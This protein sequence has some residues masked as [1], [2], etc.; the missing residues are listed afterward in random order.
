M[1]IFKNA[2]Y[3][4]QR[5]FM[6]TSTM[7][8]KGIILPKEA[9]QR[10]AASF[11]LE[12][13]HC[14]SSLELAKGSAKTNL[15]SVLECQEIIDKHVI[16]KEP[17]DGIEKLKI[18]TAL[19]LTDGMDVS[20]M[21]RMSSIIIAANL[22]IVFGEQKEICPDPTFDWS[23]GHL[24]DVMLNDSAAIEI[25]RQEDFVWHKLEPPEKEAFVFDRA[26]IDKH[27][28]IFTRY[29]NEMLRNGL[30]GTE[31]FFNENGFIRNAD[32][33]LAE[34]DFFAP[35]PKLDLKGFTVD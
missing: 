4:L 25:T 23:F 27:M 33:T 18:S 7:M 24:I 16:T 26:T 15:E 10:M 20:L 22:I 35:I 13:Y 28:A 12:I 19:F 5:K 9:L 34:E 29:A 11:L 32:G 14:K 17:L 30:D 2:K 3:K 8:E 1:G 6:S 21:S 31:I